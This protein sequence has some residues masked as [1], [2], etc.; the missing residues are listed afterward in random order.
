MTPR[1]SCRYGLDSLGDTATGS[2]EAARDTARGEAARDTAR[3]GAARDAARQSTSMSQQGGH[4]TLREEHENDPDHTLSDRHHSL[5]GEPAPTYLSSSCDPSPASA[6]AVPPPPLSPRHSP[7]PPH[8]LSPIAASIADLEEEEE[9]E[10]QGEQESLI[11]L[12]H[13]A[14]QEALPTPRFRRTLAIGALTLP[15]YT[16][17]SPLTLHMNLQARPSHRLDRSS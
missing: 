5:R 6:A 4:H 2:G 8:L 10:E 14:A 9:E 17:H 15:P 16:L 1:P 7:P 13:L 3:G 11:N 12:D